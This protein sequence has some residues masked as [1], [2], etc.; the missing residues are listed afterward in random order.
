MGVRK[1]ACISVPSL[2]SAPG[3]GVEINQSVN[4]TLTTIP[5]YY[6]YLL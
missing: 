4:L 1:G 6:D 2:G 3:R 5:T